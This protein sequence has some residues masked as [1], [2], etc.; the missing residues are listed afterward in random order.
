MLG[1]PLKNL[2]LLELLGL[3]GAAEV[4]R[5]LDLVQQREVAV[6][7]LNQ[8]AEPDLVARFIREGQVLSR[9]HHPHIVQVYRTGEEGGRR[10]LVMELVRGGSLR[11]RLQ[12]GPLPW[13]EA[14]EVALQ[15]AQALEHAHAHQVIHRDLKPGNILF[16]DQ[17]RAK[18]TDFGL[19][20]L[21]DA[22]AMTR[23]GTVMGTVLYLSPEQAVGQHVD[24]RSD[25]YALGAVLFEMLTGQPPFT[26]PSAVSIIY[27]HLNEQPPP[28][29]RVNAQVPPLVEAVVER[30][31]RKDPARRFPNATETIAA[32]RQALL[33]GEAEQAT[34]PLEE[35]A[36]EAKT[37]GEVA[38]S[39]VGR[40]DVLQI[41]REALDAAL[42]GMGRTVLI[43]GEAGLGK[44]RLAREFAREARERNVLTLSGACLYEDAPHPYAPFVELLRGYE[45]RV[46]APQ[47]GALAALW[48][49]ARILLGL[50]GAG[51][52]AE[53]AALLQQGSPVDA[54][55]NVFELLSQLLQALARQRPLLLVVDDL[56]FASPTTLQF[57]HYLARNIRRER[58]LLLGLY[59]PEE[60]L[61]GMAGGPHPLRE[62]L[63]RMGREQLYQEIPLR[64]LTE[65][66]VG[67]IAAEALNVL[68]LD[69][70]FTALLQREVEGN[71]FYLL[72]MLRLLQEQGAL[73]RVGDHWELAKALDEVRLPSSVVDVLMRRIER[74]SEEERNLLDWGAVLGHRLDVELLATVL[75]DSRLKII[76]RLY[77]LE[78]QHGLVSSDE[79][80]FYFAHGK[81]REVVY[82]ELPPSLRREYHLLAGQALEARWADRPEAVAYDLARHFAA[83]Q[84]LDKGYRYSLLA[85]ARAEATFAPA[86]AAGY[87]EQALD[88]LDK[89]PADAQDKGQRM[90]LEHR[91]GRLLA[92]I[93]RQEEACAALGRALELSRA[94]ARRDA[95]A[96][97]LLDLGVTQGNVGAWD[98]ALRL[99]EESLRLAE[100]Q[101]KT[102]LQARTLLN[103][104]FFAFEQ[105]HWEQAL[106]WLERALAVAREHGHE[107]LAAR[108]LGN[109]AIV[110]NARCER[111][112]AIALYQQSIA[113]FSQHEQLLDVA[114]GFSNVG[115]SYYGLGEYEEARRYYVQAL[116]L[117][118]KVGDIR[119]QGV[120]HL[121]LAEATL[122]LGK[123]TEAREHCIQAS[124]RFARLGF[125]LGI[126]DVD[127]VYAGIACRE[128][129]WAVAERY[130]AEAIAIYEEHGDQLN[131]A[132]AH[133]ELGKLLA[134]MGQQ[135]KAQEEL[136]RS[137][138][139]FNILLKPE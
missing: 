83:A 76:R 130:L 115:F 122:A 38:A 66:E 8:R 106:A 6:K 108:A 128:S 72:E 11:E 134:Q 81:V 23:T 80:G 24:A 57:F 73:E 33:E 112:E 70:E 36:P 102:E 104:G 98:D 91:L 16:D 42:S 110:H 48:Q 39:W 21:E 132:E 45:E 89:M 77:A 56:Q 79:Q 53:R 44:T 52:S 75:E 35:L 13:R 109:L 41:L 105:G 55:A 74:V 85:A 113:T 103:L 82:A 15:V 116:E 137:R 32:L 67:Q 126:A 5:A 99:A 28:V 19:A 40:E 47:A 64:P 29:R 2:E 58:I 9:L 27:K 1:P 124:R 43:S 50:G 65:E 46:G 62:T 25:L 59:R 17:G 26:G 94:L 119:E 84:A 129:R 139:L 97:I 111:R 63:R 49:D 87:L 78:Q 107:L 7:I 71:P 127:R 86:E 90:A 18:L 100:E 133:E 51:A 114:R 22:S 138:T 88:L 131:L 118:T 93:G 34:I 3:G 20:H 37:A 10:Y 120:V 121:H 14:V 96:E 30:L 61:P 135:Q 69:G 12:R 101:G 125:A 54:Q 92:T 95:Q 60:L 117:A 123:L 31:L 68:A 4:Y 136:E